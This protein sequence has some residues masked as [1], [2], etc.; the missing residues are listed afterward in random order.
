[1]TRTE[2]IILYVATVALGLALGAT[3]I[4]VD[5]AHAA[6]ANCQTNTL[7]LY[8][9]SGGSG[10][11]YAVRYNLKKCNNLPSSFNDIT[12][13]V[14]NRAP[15]SKVH[16]F[17]GYNCVGDEKIVNPGAKADYT[18]WLHFFNDRMSSFY[19]DY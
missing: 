12:T 3:V 5:S 2:K 18:S 8:S 16:L 7:C 4:K 15:Y 13:S 1:M 17:S 6:Y 14:W 19:Y 11:V 10:Y 9:D